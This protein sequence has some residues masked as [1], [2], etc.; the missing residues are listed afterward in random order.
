[1]RLVAIL[2]L[3]ACGSSYADGVDV[4]IILSGEVVPGVY[5][6]VSFGNEAPPP[7]VYEQP[8]VIEPQYTS[9][10][11]IYLHVPPEH[12]KNW[13]KHCGEY[14]ACNRPV[15][16]VRSR[17]FEPEYQRHYQEHEREREIER[18][19]WEAREREHDRGR[20]HEDHG[21]GHDGHDRRDDHDK[22]DGK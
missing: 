12:A 20:E 14:Q 1:M 17:E 21:H 18:R 5:G 9:V 10:P 4:R 15:F 22:R 8:V 3:L 7:V 16:F 6:R 11:P 13:R 2:L 19:R